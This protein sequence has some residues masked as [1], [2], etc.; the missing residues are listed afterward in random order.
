MDCEHWYFVATGCTLLDGIPY[1]RVQWHQVDETP[2]AP[3]ERVELIIPQPKAAEVYYEACGWVDQ[4][5]RHWQATLMMETKIEVHRWDQCVNHSILA[6]CIVD[7]SILQNGA[8][9]GTN[10]SATSHF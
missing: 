4:H 10:F 5:N 3:P 7:Q 8:V 6:M 9:C 1:S 2:D